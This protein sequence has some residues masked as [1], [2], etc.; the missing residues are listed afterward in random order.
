[1]RLPTVAALALLAAPSLHAQSPAPPAGASF[2]VAAPT[3][4]TWS[5]APLPGGSEATFRNSAS[6]IPQLTIAC[7]RAARRVTISRPASGAAPHL[8]IWTSSLARNVPASFNPA[9]GRISA[10]LAAFD[11]LLDAITFSRGRFSVTV[12]GGPALV[13][14]A[15]SEPARVIE[16]CRV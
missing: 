1:M 8:S 12:A 9:T 6:T 4:G 15:W 7:T 11:S 3:S 5:Y 14:P 2:G 16:D 10:E 13:V